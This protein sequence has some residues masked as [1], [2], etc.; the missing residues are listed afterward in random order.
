MKF[1]ALFALILV[2]HTKNAEAADLT[3]TIDTLGGADYD[4]I[5][6]AIG[7]QVA[8]AVKKLSE[9]SGAVRLAVHPTVLVCALV[10]AFFAAGALRRPATSPLYSA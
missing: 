7:P 4:D 2:M 1:V 9:E 6:A 8:A 10:A 5:V 3:T